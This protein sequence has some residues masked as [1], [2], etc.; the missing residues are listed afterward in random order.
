MIAMGDNTLNSL[1]H[2]WSGKAA[3][4]IGAWATDAGLVI[5]QKHGR[6]QHRLLHGQLDR[7]G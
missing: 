3:Q 5:G 6:T 4:I 1:L 7:L 2:A